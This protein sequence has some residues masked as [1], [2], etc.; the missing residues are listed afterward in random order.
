[1]CGH[2][3]REAVVRVV[4][5]ENTCHCSVLECMLNFS[6]LGAPENVHILKHVTVS[7]TLLVGLHAACFL[8]CFNRFISYTLGSVL[9]KAF[10]LYGALLLSPGTQSF[11]CSGINVLYLFPTCW[12]GFF[13]RVI[14][15]DSVVLWHP[16]NCSLSICS[17][18]RFF[19]QRKRCLPSTI[20]AQFM[21]SIFL[22]KKLLYWVRCDW[23]VRGKSG[24]IF[25][26]GV[27]PD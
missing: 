3:E 11:S 15:L 5:W 16:V 23:K 10:L 25:S 20:E 26:K 17:S 13:G 8:F 27:A 2:V 4:V 24:A 14:P 7:L 21:R 18:D 22:F 19:L 6:R 1:V 9:I 12:S